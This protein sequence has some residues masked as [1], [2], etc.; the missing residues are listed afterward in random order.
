ML[1]NQ[2]SY[3]IELFDPKKYTV[4]DETF[5]NNYETVE[6][7]SSGIQLQL[8]I[9]E[10]NLI[11]RKNWYKLT[12]KQATMIDRIDFCLSNLP[13][14][15]TKS[16]INNRIF[17][18]VDHFI[19]DKSFYYKKFKQY[20]FCPA[21]MTIDEAVK[22]SKDSEFFNSST[23]L[24][25]KS[26]NGYSSH[27]IKVLKNYSEENICNHIELWKNFKNWT[28]SIIYVPKL[29]NDIV[30][31][32]RVYYLVTKQRINDN[33]TV[34][35]YWYDEFIS[36]RAKT[37]FRGFDNCDTK[38]FIESFL[39]NFD[40]TPTP[41]DFFYKRTLSHKEYIKIFTSDEY[42]KIKHDLTQHLN[43]ITKEIFDHITCANDYEENYNDELNRNVT[44]HLYGL[45]VIITDD[46][47]IKI[48]E[49]NGCPTLRD[50]DVEVFNYKRMLDEILKLTTDNLYKP[51]EEI[52][53]MYNSKYGYFKNSD[54]ETKFCDMKFVK[55]G[56]YTKKL[57]L[58]VYFARTIYETYPFIIN[59]FFN[60]FRTKK[61]QRVKNPNSSQ[62]QLFYGQRDLYIREQSSENYYDELLEWNKSKSGKCSKVL[63]K[64]QGITYFLAS[65]DRMYAQIEEFDFVPKSILFDLS[66]DNSI[67]KTFVKNVKDENPDEYF[68][69]KPVFGSQGK[70][71]SILNSQ[72]PNTFINKM[73]KAESSF[74]YNRFIISKYIKNPKLYNNKKFNL[75]FYVLICIK[76][77][78]TFGNKNSDVKYY[79]LKD[80]QIYFSTL[81]YLTQM[82]N[83]SEEIRNLTI[84]KKL[85]DDRASEIS[86]AELQQLV[87]MTNL[88]IVKN[89]SEKLATKISLTEFVNTLDNLCYP[90]SYVQ[91][92]KYQAQNIIDKTI[93]AI[94]YDMRP[95]NR[96]VKNSSAFNLIAYDVMLDDN[97]KLHL[98][99]VRVNFRNFLR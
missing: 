62:M 35:G 69:I 2:F 85:D 88:Q 63:N 37:T 79:I 77:L 4:D 56:E 78:P 14:I 6:F 50:F 36:Y 97:D 28:L 91:H 5:E 29:W 33:I 89:I 34:N 30:A 45:D 41:L 31:T 64:I 48:I 90:E 65:K 96:F 59:G 99:L 40:D 58:P 1:R 21:H 73:K 15:Q 83:V 71:I 20:S 55:C 42:N 76:K 74:G 38:D 66:Q 87:H 19:S 95:L 70:G 81:P 13:Q 46:L 7:R 53:Y 68:I 8:P 98:L 47:D 80:S 57:K 11:G 22:A 49:M 27:G 93:N 44:F 75:R 3:Y 39:T 82:E 84:D 23:P 60:E 16:I 12:K 9:F 54:V 61:Y 92:V 18:D 52:K 26:G 24:I 17:L 67:L 25:L 32:N 43:V 72:D 51:Q 86:V 94:K 10:H